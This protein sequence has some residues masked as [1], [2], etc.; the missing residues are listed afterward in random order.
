VTPPGT[1]AR[2]GGDLVARVSVDA[3]KVGDE[4]TVQLCPG[5]EGPLR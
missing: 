2:C 5:G 4:L 3:L 1:I